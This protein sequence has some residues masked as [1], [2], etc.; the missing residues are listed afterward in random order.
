MNAMRLL[1]L[2]LPAFL[3]GLFLIPLTPPAQAGSATWKLDPTSGDWNTAAN[4]TP[5]T[6]PNG[7]DDIATFGVS[8][9]T[10]ISLSAMITLGGMQFESGASSYDIGV[11]ASAPLSFN[12]AG[13]TNE[14][15]LTQSIS[16]TTSTVDF[17]NASTAGGNVIYTNTSTD[18]FISSIITFHDDA[19][20][21]SATFVN[22]GT[23]AYGQGKVVFTNNASA[24][25]SNITVS[26]VFGFGSL[27]AAF[28][29]DESTAAQSTILYD[30]GAFGFFGSQ[31]TAANS[32]LTCS[33]SSSVY[34]SDNS[35]A[36][37]ATIAC[38]DA[39][40]VYFQNSATA[41][42]TTITCSAGSVNFLD[43]S[44][45]GAATI[46]ADDTT[47]HFQERSDGGTAR[48]V[49]TNASTLIVDRDRPVFRVGSLEGD[50]AATINRVLLI[51]GNNLDATFS[52]NLESSLEGDWLTKL[53]TGTWTLT[54]TGSYPGTTTVID[55][56][57]LVTSASTPTGSGPVKVN[58]GTLGGSGT[59]AGPVTIGT[60]SGTGAFL[61]PAH[62]G[63]KQLTLTIQS[64]LTFNSDATY[65]YT[66]KAKGNKSKIDKVIANGVTINSGA[67][68]NLSGTTQGPLTQ[69]TALTLIKNTAATPISGSFSNLP[70][71]GIVDV[72]GNNLQASYEGGDGNDLT[73]TVVP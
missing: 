6:V 9:V 66:F 43:F 65:T 5:K 14:S 1:C 44:T 23:P 48:I 41:G 50:G 54:G 8:N 30:K 70:D 60:G 22:N 29:Y 36:E 7:T 32:T 72:N 31:A 12:G 39:S 35:T 71:G 27:G 3:P 16:C 68:I 58:G 19:N 42:A 38:S 15:G 33:A 53:G 2:M 63:N 61:A 11:I 52:G 10:S 73:L 25:S 37:A 57:L 62:G 56:A 18:G 40:N 51:G 67:I 45:A 24:G 28:F 49:L 4:W 26:G 17:Y 21:G 59:I 55:G 34:F 64:S 20:A 47:V 13:V 69:G 46:T